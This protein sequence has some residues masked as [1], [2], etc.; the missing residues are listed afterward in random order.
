MTQFDL[1][2]GS[3]ILHYCIKSETIHESVDRIN[4]FENIQ[5]FDILEK[6][7]KKFLII[8]NK[9]RN[10]LYMCNIQDT[11]F[12]RSVVFKE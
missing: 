8:Q 4:N 6:V 5:N 2:N 1:S 10:L 12:F 9:I 11:G 7:W 3:E